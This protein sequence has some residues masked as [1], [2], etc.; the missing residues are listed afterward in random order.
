MMTLDSGEARTIE[1]VL[2]IPALK[3]SLIFVIKVTNLGYQVKSTTDSCLIKDQEGKI[4]IPSGR[5]VGNYMN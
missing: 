2:H 5:R 3:K 1:N 4:L